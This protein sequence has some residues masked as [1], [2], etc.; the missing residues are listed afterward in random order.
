[1]QHT[2]NTNIATQFDVNTAI[3]LQHMAFWT[4]N[5]L[6]NKQNIHD[7]QCWTYNTLEAFSDI[8]PYW[9]LRQTRTII[10]KCIEKGLLSKGNYNQ[11]KY[12]RTVWYALSYEGFCLF[13][14]LI[15][16][17]YLKLLIC[18]E[19]PDKPLSS[20]ICQ[21]W[22]IHLSKLTD[23]FAEIDTP[24]PDINNFINKNNINNINNINKRGVIGGKNE[25]VNDTSTPSVENQ[26]SVEDCPSEKEKANNINAKSD[27][28]KNQPFKKPVRQNKEQLDIKS[29]LENNPF[30]IPKQM[31]EDWMT[32]RRK[33]RAPITLTV[34][35]KIL[36][37]LTKIQKAGKNPLDAFESYVASG[38]Q[39]F[40]ADWYLK[41]KS[42]SGGIKPQWD[43][44]SV[45]RA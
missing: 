39:G 3:F 31:I 44:D 38:Y 29:I 45:E 19:N 13:P 25:I 9:T 22:Q 35:H 42:S 8:F 10:D 26:K 16:E 40:E 37:E 28:Q 18:T 23:P 11:T 43:V 6:A 17:K 12:D 27:Y 34:W 30:Q 14:E 4:F 1:M 2:F 32:N 33:K 15:Q 21:K 20:L 41:N 24:I 36:K 5:N 7:G